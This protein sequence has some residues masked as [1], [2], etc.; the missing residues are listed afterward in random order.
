MREYELVF[1]VQPEL[2]EEAVDAFVERVQQIMQDNGGEVKA[3]EQL[4]SRRLAYPIR[5]YERGYYVLLQARLGQP[6]IQEVERAL[7]LSEDV[8]R[9]LLVRIE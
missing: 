8:L 4:G 1:I 2:E 3:A 7:K 6:A 5:K 9:H